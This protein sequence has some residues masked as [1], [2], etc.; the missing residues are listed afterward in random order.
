MAKTAIGAPPGVTKLSIHDLQAELGRRQ[1][2]LGKLQ[3]KY[4]KYIASAAAIEEQI[5][6]LGGSVN[7][8]LGGGRGSRPRNAE[9]LVQSMARLLKGKTMSVTDIAQA[10]QDAGYRTTSPN[11]RTIV[12]QALIK[13]TIFKNVSRGQYTLKG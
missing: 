1:R 3:R 6:G 13:N 7:G 11:F 4:A 12:N 10:V 9:N 5:R 8:T 2:G